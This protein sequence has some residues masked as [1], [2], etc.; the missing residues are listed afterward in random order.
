MVSHLILS[1]PGQVMCTPWWSIAIVL[2]DCMN[3][4]VNKMLALG[5]IKESLCPRWRSPVL[6]SKPDG[7]IHIC[8]DCHKVNE[9]STF[10]VYLIPS[11]DLFL[12]MVGGVR[13]LS[14]LDLT[15]GYWQITDVRKIRKR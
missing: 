9:M 11:I 1:P 7:S 2:Q 14:T 10:A 8:I 12:D 5:V 3:Q 6:F 15:K 13:F 4:K